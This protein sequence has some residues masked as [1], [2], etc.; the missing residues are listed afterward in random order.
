MSPQVLCNCFI[1]LIWVNTHTYM[2]WHKSYLMHLP[3]TLACQKDLILQEFCY[4]PI[5]HSVL[6]PKHAHSIRSK[7][8]EESFRLSKSDPTTK[9][10]SW[11]SCW[12]QEQP[13]SSTHPFLLTRPCVCCSQGCQMQGKRA[14]AEPS[15]S[16]ATY[17]QSH[18]TAPSACT[19]HKIISYMQSATL[20]QAG[21]STSWGGRLSWEKN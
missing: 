19:L 4:H 15:L 12:L 6:K 21:F 17:H 5:W 16:A 11:Q 8:S 18:K 20:V 7:L 9:P 10:V 13:C 2:Q 1:W 14:E 3:H